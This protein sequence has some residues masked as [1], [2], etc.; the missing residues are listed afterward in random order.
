MMDT[1]QAN[2]LELLVDQPPVADAR[3]G[4]AS[5]SRP[6]R[7]T[8]LSLAVIAH[9]ARLQM[10][11]SSEPAHRAQPVAARLSTGRMRGDRDLAAARTALSRASR[12]CA[13]VERRA[14]AAGS[15]GASLERSAAPRPRCSPSRRSP[16]RC[17]PPVRRAAARSSSAPF[18][19]RARPGP[20]GLSAPVQEQAAAAQR[21]AGEG[22]HAPSWPAP[23][24]PTARWTQDWRGSGLLEHRGG[25]R[26]RGMHRRRPDLGD[27]LA[28]IAAANSAAFLAPGGADGEGGDGNAARHL[29]NGEQRI[30]AVEGLGLHRDAEHRHAVLAAVIPA[31]GRRRRRRR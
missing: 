18:E 10:P 16:L 2:G 6:V 9:A 11:G 26:R 22:H 29:R 13:R 30:H 21:I 1:S 25:L 15:R 27:S 24:M 23:T 14:R 28:M 31:G 20:P 3:P 19:D 4:A 7:S 5:T 17:A 8:E 12:S